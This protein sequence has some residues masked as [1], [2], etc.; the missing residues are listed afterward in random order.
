MITWENGS[1]IGCKWKLLIFERSVNR[2][3]W[4]TLSVSLGNRRFSQ[5]G[6]FWSVPNLTLTLFSI[7]SLFQSNAL[8]LRPNYSTTKQYFKKIVFILKTLVIVL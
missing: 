5:S 1:S 6:M 4:F 7:P 2:T 8:C 3:D